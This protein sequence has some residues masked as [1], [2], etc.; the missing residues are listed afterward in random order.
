MVNNRE[1]GYSS[2]MDMKERELKSY[3]EPVAD[4]EIT[5]EH[6]AWMNE[7]IQD[8]LDR[9]RSGLATFK[10]LRDIMRKYSDI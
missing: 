4:S 3:L 7:R 2:D 5:P 9:K 10:D 6:R 1:L 8:A